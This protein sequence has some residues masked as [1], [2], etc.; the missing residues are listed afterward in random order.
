[1]TYIALQNRISREVFFEDTITNPIRREAIRGAIQDAI[2]YY[3]PELFAFNEQQSTNTTVADFEYYPL[4]DDFIQMVTIAVQTGSSVWAT[5]EPRSF[6]E[7]EQA[8]LRSSRGCPRMYCTFN[9]QLRVS[10]VPNSAYDM[11]LSYIRKL[12][13]LVNDDDENEWTL[14]AEPLIRAK[15]KSLLLLDATHDVEGAAVHDREAEMWFKRLQ[16]RAIQHV[17][18]NQIRPQVF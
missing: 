2:Q 5:M 14:Y 8:N 9:M 1:M 16:L 6:D 18:V 10:P 4:P 15:A 7:L 17:V 11:R 3:E 13:P 12:P